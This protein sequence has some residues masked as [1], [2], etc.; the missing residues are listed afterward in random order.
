MFMEA[1][2]LSR[3]KHHSIVSLWGVVPVEERRTES[4]L[5]DDLLHSLPDIPGSFG[6][7]GSGSLFDSGDSSS[8][9]LGLVMERCD[10]SLEDFLIKQ[11]CLPLKAA[12][13]I[14]TR[15]AGG[16]K[17]LH[18]DAP[19]RVVHGDLKP[20]N[21]LLKNKAREVK[22][23]DFGLSSV[24]E[25]HTM[26]LGARGLLGHNAHAGAPA[27]ATPAWAAPELLEV[28]VHG[29][30]SAAPRSLPCDVYAF[31]IILHQLLVGKPPY[32]SD[33]LE[34]IY[35]MQ[36]MNNII[37][38]SRPDWADWRQ[39]RSL[40]AAAAVL[41]KLQDIHLGTKVWVRCD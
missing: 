11:P 39:R 14:A 19:L 23:T 38:G 5:L 20:A 30:G 22:L 29:P 41:D 28:W 1:A 35:P 15:I 2:V 18:N 24:I 34:P 40:E 10:H 26:S 9:S 37:K 36:M 13:H 6:R 16:L 4:G 25:V 27:G 7:L 31:A 17:Y 8:L 3:L 21:V 32:L 33:S 12:L